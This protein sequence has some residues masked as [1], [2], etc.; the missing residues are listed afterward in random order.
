MSYKRPVQATL[1][2]RLREPRRFLQVLAGPR[3]AG[4]TTLARQAMAE[5]DGPT[6]YASADAPGLEEQIWLEQQWLQARRLAQEASRGLLVL[7]EIQKV[8]GWSE[9][10]KRLWDE[11]SLAGLELKVLLL[12]SAPLLL[13][14]GLSES[15]AGRFE[16]LPVT[17]W[18]FP[19][20]Q[21]AFGWELERFVYF[22]GYPG[23]APLVDEGERWRDYV[24]DGLI[25]TTISR[26]VLLLARI[27][28][29]AL[30]RRLFF[31][32]CS[33]SGQILSYQ[34]MVGQLQD[35]GNTTTLAHYLDLL[36]AAGM[37]SGLQK[38][39]GQVVRQRAS[40]PRLMVQNNALL[41][42][43]QA[44]DFASV[45]KAPQLWGRWVESAVG[46]YL[47]NRARSDGYR[48]SYWRNGNLEVDFVLEKG[49]RL[50]ALEV[51]SGRRRDSLSGLDAFRKAFPTAQLGVVGRAGMAVQDFLSSPPLESF[52]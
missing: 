45:R 41:S 7:D 38:Y 28:K 1:T 40:S 16:L 14:R 24:R 30:L 43:S 10:V 8:G 48:L 18:S 31:L 23:A 35:A 51:K 2:R 22:G 50:L 15:L 6:W 47:V 29:P 33:Y 12:G 42:A 52:G 5:F 21:Q 34:K 9:I 36:E 20:M 49:R 4:K 25:E 32:S 39:S 46:A 37:V 44:E 19:E 17:H 3:Q 26:D 13:Q 11:D 27:D